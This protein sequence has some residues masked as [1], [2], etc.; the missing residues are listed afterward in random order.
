MMGHWVALALETTFP[1]HVQFAP[2][3]WLTRDI[4]RFEIN[5]IGNI[6]RLV[7]CLKSDDGMQGN[8]AQPDL[9]GLWACGRFGYR[10]GS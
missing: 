3:L 6:Q 9:S 10:Y 8:V 1:I 2:D 4:F 7:F 5:S